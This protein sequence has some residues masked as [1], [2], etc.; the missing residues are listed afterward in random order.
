MAIS[1]LGVSFNT[2]SKGHK[3]VAGAAYRSGE[4]LFD[5]T[6]GIEHDFENRHDVQYSNI[7]L[8]QGADQ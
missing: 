3:A 8:P 5:E 1:Y 2:R 7:I 4:K 6:Y